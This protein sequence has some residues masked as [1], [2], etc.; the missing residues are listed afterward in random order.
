[1]QEVGLLDQTIAIEAAPSI[2][3][4]AG[5]GSSSLLAAMQR[6]S[7]RAFA[8]LL[9]AHWPVALGL[10]VIRGT[11]TAALLVGGIASLLP[12][13]LAKFRPGSFA[14]RVVIATCLMVYSMLFIAQTGGM[15]EMHFHVFGSMAFLLIYR[16]WR[17]PVIA[18][19]VIAVHHAVFNYIQTLGYPDLVFAD[20]HGWHIVGIHAVFVIFEG[21]GLVYM[22]RMLHSEVE[23]SEALVDHAGRL[24]EGDLTQRVPEGTGAVAAAASALNDATEALGGIVHN[25]T[26]RA[27]ETGAVSGALG[28]ALRQQRSAASAVGSV[29]ARVAEGAARQQKETK[30]MTAAFD[31]MVS[32]VHGVATNVGAVADASGRAAEAATVSAQL[33]ERSLTAIGRMEAAVQEA[34]KQ[35]RDLFQLSDQVDRMLQTVTQVAAQ[36]NML[37]LN[38]SIEAARAGASGS[39]FAVVAEEIRRLADSSAKAVREASSTGS[40]IRGGIE[41]VMQGMERGLA[42]S[43]EGLAVAG[44][45][46]ATLQE[47]KRRSTTGVEDLR[48][49]A[50]ISAEIAAETERIL[51]ESSTGAARRTVLALVE[52]SAANGQAAEDAGVAAR[53]I[54]SVVDAIA[55]SAKELDR[56]SGSLQQASLRFVV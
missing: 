20:H 10:A 56:I 53:E 44:S 8:L 12:L 19:G 6:Q 52:V 15:I 7:D 29:V 11:W 47:V 55:T 22:A 33:M 46:E 14:T 4:P 51:G 36:T 45:L 39:G 35:S 23:Q 9:L 18:G 49:V 25:L 5:T 37:A 54:E 27:A 24:G 42:E 48:S 17:L 30:A 31:D 1:M 38:A 32:A 21:V 2:R 50:R 41:Q 16:D 40:R 43:T 13:A 3:P 34:A 26:E 28:E